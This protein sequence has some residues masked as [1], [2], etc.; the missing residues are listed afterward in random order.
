MAGFEL[1][2]FDAACGLDPGVA[3]AKP[4]PDMA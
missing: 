3:R 2:T 4:N 1:Q